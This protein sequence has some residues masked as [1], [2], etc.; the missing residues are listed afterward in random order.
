[1]KKFFLSRMEWYAPITATCTNRN[2]LWPHPP[3]TWCEDWTHEV[4][5]REKRMMEM[6]Q[7]NK[8]PES[9]DEEVRQRE[10]TIPCKIRHV[11][12]VERERSMGTN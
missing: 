1:M 3:E 4:E 8:P 9:W 2:H 11:Q 12:E 10:L 5:V 7:R 6:E